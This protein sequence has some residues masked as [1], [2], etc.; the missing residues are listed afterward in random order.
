MVLP[1]PP[2]KSRPP[3]A[4]ELHVFAGLWGRA[5]LTRLHLGVTWLDRL[6]DAL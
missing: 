4:V 5:S 3:M 2:R 6:F 1:R